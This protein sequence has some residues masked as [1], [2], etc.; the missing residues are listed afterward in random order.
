MSDH[1]IIIFEKAR[2]LLKEGEISGRE[3]EELLFLLSDLL[4][5]LGKA[6]LPE[7]EGG[8]FLASNPGYC[9]VLL[10]LLK[11]Q[12]AE[13]DTLRKLSASLTANLDMSAVLNAIT[14]E[15]MRLALDARA[16]HIL[17]TG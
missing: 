4:S 1:R 12:T 11:Q 13:L 16:V 9:R 14:Q 10:S 17:Q 2:R 5:A 15:A 8:L 7:S 3:R 6:D